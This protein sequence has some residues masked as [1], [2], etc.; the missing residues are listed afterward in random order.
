MVGLIVDSGY[1]RISDT[2][3]VNSSL[4]I[5]K[6]PLLLFIETMLNIAFSSRLRTSILKIVQ[7]PTMVGPILVNGY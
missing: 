2:L 4:K 5:S 6:M 1:K 3:F 7:G